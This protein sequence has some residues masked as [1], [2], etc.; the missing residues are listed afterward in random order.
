MLPTGRFSSPAVTST[1]RARLG[2]RSY[3]GGDLNGDFVNDVRDFRLFRTAFIANNGAGAFAALIGG[4]VP[5]PTA[6]AL[7]AMGLVGLALGR[8]TRKP[9]LVVLCVL[10]AGSIGGQVATAAT[11]VT[12][13]GSADPGLAPD[14]NGGIDDV[15]TT[16]LSVDG[17]RGSGFFGLP[18][19]HS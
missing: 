7:A 1:T 19:R 6:L 16:T 4:H 5:E 3:L 17:G 18:A 12:Y 10:Y 14:A 11:P 13:V 9:L 15:W 2:C 8:R